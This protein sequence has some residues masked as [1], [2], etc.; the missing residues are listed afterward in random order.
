MNYSREV[1]YNRFGFNEFQA[2]VQSHARCKELIPVDVIKLTTQKTNVNPRIHLRSSC[3]AV[4]DKCGQM[5]SLHS[6]IPGNLFRRHSGRRGNRTHAHLG[7][8]K[9]Q[10]LNQSSK[11]THTK[12]DQ[13]GRRPSGKRQLSGARWN[14][15]L[16]QKAMQP[17]RQCDSSPNKRTG[18]IPDDH[19][20][21]TAAIRRKS[22]NIC[23]RNSMGQRCQLKVAQSRSGIAVMGNV[24]AVNEERATGPVRNDTSQRPKGNR[25]SGRQLGPE[26][27]G[28]HEAT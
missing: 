25:K 4:P 13:D 9:I 1:L 2:R 11:R 16:N 20:G 28:R 10:Y 14:K 24:R 21:Q 8:S 6:G 12:I 17:T 27:R 19:G 7:A 23:P 22:R 5:S 26:G 3:L 15:K 18:P